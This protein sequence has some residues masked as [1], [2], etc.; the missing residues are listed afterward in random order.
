MAASAGACACA[1]I[2]PGQKLRDADLAFVGK[3]QSFRDDGPTRIYTIAVEKVYK[4]SV[5]PTAEIRGGNPDDNVGSDCD[6]VFTVDQEAGGYFK[7]GPEQWFVGTCNRATRAELDRAATELGTSAEPPPQPAFIARGPFGDSPFAITDGAGKPI[8][9][10]PANPSNR[11]PGALSPCPGGEYLFNGLTIRRISDLAPVGTLGDGRQPAEMRC[12]RADGRAAVGFTTSR[13]STRGK[14]VRLTPGHM[15]T[16]AKGPWAMAAL[17]D[18]RSALAAINPGGTLV[19]VDNTSGRRRVVRRANRNCVDLELSPDQTQVAETVSKHRG[20]RVTQAFIHDLSRRTSL[21]RRIDGHDLVWYRRNRIAAV[22]YD[23][24]ARLYDARLRPVSK[25][26]LV[27]DGGTFGA[28]GDLW[29]IREGEL[30]RRGAD[31][32]P[33]KLELPIRGPLLPIPTP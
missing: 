17:G 3:V 19:L 31:G 2:S 6:E 29:W 16:L 22:T 5:G 21:R 26:F 11:R 15:R 30:N 10:A 27:S 20:E 32:F 4:G 1:A 25:P 33:A 14:L 9:Y 28:R 24:H 12:L 8:S 23:N 13:L 7:G 18:R